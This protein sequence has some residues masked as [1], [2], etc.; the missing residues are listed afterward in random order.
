MALC[1]LYLPDVASGGQRL[2]SSRASLL[3]IHLCAHATNPSQISEIRIG[4]CV[5]LAIIVHAAK[6]TKLCI[7]CRFALHLSIDD[8]TFRN[9]PPKQGA[10][11]NQPTPLTINV[12]VRAASSRPVRA[13]SPQQWTPA[14][15]H[16]GLRRIT[17]SHTRSSSDTRSPSADMPPP[18]TA[19]GEENN[20]KPTDPEWT[21][22]DAPC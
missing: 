12:S 19:L 13:S 3:L 1:T 10:T 2:V 5:R 20:N 6:G 17:S 22:W 15:L 4:F 18:R 14:G 8:T 16:D 11:I 9:C 7:G 21:L